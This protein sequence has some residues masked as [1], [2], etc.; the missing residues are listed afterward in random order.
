MN[1]HLQ[2]FPRGRFDARARAHQILDEAM[3]G[4]RY[5]ANV[6]R[7]ALVV[8]G[9][10]SRWPPFVRAFPLVV[11]PPDSSVESTSPHLPA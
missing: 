8:R 10:T 1:T 4:K 3:A 2:L 5:S 11:F 9:T 6:I 7:W